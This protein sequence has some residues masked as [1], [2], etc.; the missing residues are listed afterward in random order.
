MQS[1]FLDLI[2]VDVADDVCL[3]TNIIRYHDDN[4][5]G[6]YFSQLTV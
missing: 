5:I 2:N 1:A 4:I 3:Y 6:L